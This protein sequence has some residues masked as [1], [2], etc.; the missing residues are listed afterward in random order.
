MQKNYPGCKYPL[1]SLFFNLKMRLT[2]ALLFFSNLLIYAGPISGQSMH[3]VKISLSVKGM[4]LKEVLRLIEKQSSF[5]IGY[6]TIDALENKKISIEVKGKSIAEILNEV[7][8]PENTDIKQ[9]SD[10]YIIINPKRMVVPTVVSGVVRDKRTGQTIPGVSIK[11]KGTVIGT[12]TDI[13]GAYSLSVKEDR[14]SFTLVVSYIGYKSQEFVVG[15]SASAIRQNVQLQEDLLGLD[16]V[17]VTGQGIDVSKRRLS[18]NV[19]SISGADIEKTPGSRID[20]LLQAKLPNAQ[21]RLTGGQAGATSIIRA[22]GVV[23]AFKNSTPVIY[24]DGVRMDNLN[25]ASTLGGGSASGSAVSALSDIPMDNIEKI[26]YINGGAATTLYGSDAANGVI[27]IITKK[28]GGNRTSITLNVEAGPEVATTDFLHFERTKDML[29]E[30][31]AFQKYNVGINGSKDGLGYSFTGGYMNSSGVQIMDQNSNERIDMRSGFKANIGDKITYESSFTFVN[32]SYK[33]SRNGNQGGYTGLWFLE[34]GASATTGPKPNFSPLIDD[35]SEEDFQKMKAYVREA[36]R[37]QDNEIVVNRF[38]TS[39]TFNYRPTENLVV[40]AVGGIDYRVMRNK[41]VTTNQYITHT[42]GTPSVGS[43]SINNADRKYWGLTLELNGQH[44]AELGDFS[45]ITTFG[46]QLFRNEDRQVAYNG[47]N[48]RDGMRDIRSAG[49]T[50]SNEM[51]TEDV[52]YGVYIQE[53]FGFKNKFFIDLGLRGD[54]NSAFGKDIGTQFYPK[55]GF[56]YIPSAEPWFANAVPAISSAKLRASYGIAG[57]FP[58]AFQNIKTIG[59]EGYLGGIGATFGTPGSELRPEKA[60]TL[61][62]G[63]DLGLLQDRIVLTAGF[64]HTITRDALFRVPSIPSTGESA[65][66]RNVGEILNRGLEF[67][68]NAVPVKTKDFSLSVN[69]S[70]NTLYNKVVTSQ[71]NAPFNLNGFSERTI[72]TVVQEGFPVGFIR[73]G[74]G[75]FGADGV[76]N[77]T[78][79]LQNLGTT[80]P[81]LFGSM[82]LNLQ[83]KDFNF[84][85]NADYQS[86]AYA[87]NWDSQFRFNYGAGNEG[88]PQGEIDKNKRVNWLNFTNMFIEKTDFIKVRT[89]GASYLFRGPKLGKAI[90]NLTIGFSVVNPLNFASSSFDPEATTSG[91]AQGQG[92]A[93]TGGISYATYSA[94]RQFLGSVKVNF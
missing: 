67:S 55:V 84:F 22:R 47:T 27:Q 50:T 85:A 24:V 15:R 71:G 7:M 39:Q 18:T 56:S 57:N 93:T 33:R 62:A 28:G 4:P 38:Q 52:N 42:T 8:S 73:G 59:F 83:Y 29:F 11:V 9:I 61:E 43:G 26:E 80:I 51:Y 65:S 21:I 32:N 23:S 86:G 69:L 13:D 91:S 66:F 16:E 49:A 76:M 25:T 53:N 88:V 82:G 90:K 92:G 70:L 89:I 5:I 31:G 35:L 37:L 40:K 74:Y 48:V 10:K 41:V 58:P 1:W 46:G 12:Q 14:Q 94:P 54:G 64:Y 34:S 87:S 20:Q 60:T 6:K 44:K 79:P 81:D 3:D 17:V 45:F 36:E 19:T 68:M 30:T 78:T 77:S 72:Q 75:T 63:L 2:I